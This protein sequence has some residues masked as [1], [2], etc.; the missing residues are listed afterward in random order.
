MP[1]IYGEASV[2]NRYI[3]TGIIA[4]RRDTLFKFDGS[5]ESPLEVAE[6]VDLNRVLEN[7]GKIRMVE[8]SRFSFGVDTP[9]E[10]ELANK[11]MSKDQ[12][13]ALYE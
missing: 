7:G 8:A 13:V 9:E 10:L 3:Q 6:S 11:L 12:Y 2:S 5:E 4:F 1:S